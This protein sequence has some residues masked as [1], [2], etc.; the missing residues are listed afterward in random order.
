MAGWGFARW[1]GGGRASA[2]DDGA[3]G[4]DINTEH[5]QRVEHL[6][7]ALA[8]ELRSVE[9]NE[10]EQRA[11]DD[12]FAAFMERCAASERDDWEVDGRGALGDFV[13]AALG[14]ALAVLSARPRTTSVAEAQHRAKLALLIARLRVKLD[15]LLV[16]LRQNPV[17]WALQ[18][19]EWCD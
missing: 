19:S 1:F 18:A 8:E 12:E 10:D 2:V 11:I 6:E 13:R 7:A 9:L 16:T 3:G 14:K 5:E 4:E 15:E 17:R